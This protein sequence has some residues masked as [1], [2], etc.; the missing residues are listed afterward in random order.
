MR[1]LRALAILGI[2]IASAKDDNFDRYAAER[3]DRPAWDGGVDKSPQAKSNTHD[4][5]FRPRIGVKKFGLS[6]EP[7][8]P[9]PKFAADRKH[10]ESDPKD[11]HRTGDREHEANHDS[12]RKESHAKP[13]FE[14]YVKH[15]AEHEL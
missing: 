4:S 7:I 3:G 6:R 1:L 2:S 10:Y 12:N 8:D 9:K 14:F 13:H 15:A 5:A 11:R